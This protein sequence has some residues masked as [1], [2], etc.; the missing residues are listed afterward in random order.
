VIIPIMDTLLVTTTRTLAGRPI[1]SGGRDH[2]THRLVALGLSERQAALLLYGFAIAGGFFGLAFGAATTSLGSIVVGFMFLVLMGLL[3]AYLA[4]MHVYTAA[5]A[6]ANHPVTIMVSDLLHKKRALEFVL[7]VVLFTLAAYAAYLLR[8]DGQIPRSQMLVLEQSLALIIAAYAISFGLLG[9]YRGEWSR[10]SV[11]D[12]HRLAKAVAVGALLS[13]SGMV[14]F[15]RAAEFSRS[16]LVLNAL[17]VAVLTISSRLTF[18][19]IDSIRRGFG[20]AGE[21]T[22]IYGA[23]GRGEI[24]LRELFGNSRS[25]LRAV[26]FIDD[27][28]RLL[29]RDLLGVPILG[30]GADLPALVMAHGITRLVVATPSLPERQWDQLYRL[31]AVSR[32]QLL[33]FEFG[34]EIVEVPV[35]RSLVAA[36]GTD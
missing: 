5:E 29:G 20:T 1:S 30:K 22:L 21:P 16:V 34:I 28:A 3:A 7:D 15:F 14:F 25:G 2:T 35:P 6:R 11:A 9:V 12:V 23:G 26:G 33:R 10:A 18:R 4:R 24:V 27:N 19:S 13:T 31:S 36:A 8:W 32:V 17:L